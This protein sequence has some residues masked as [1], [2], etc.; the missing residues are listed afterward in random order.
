MKKLLL[1]IF[2][3]SIGLN[4]SAQCVPVSGFTGTGVA[5][6]PIQLEPV[7]ACL[8]CG[9]QER[10]ISVHTLADT[11]L[12]IELAPGNPP[13]DVTVYADFFRLIS[14]EGL[15]SGLSYT[16]DAALDTTY[17]EVENPFGYWVNQGDTTVG[18][19]ST[20][21]CIS[22]T[23]SAAD[24]TAAA[25]GGPNSDGLYPLTIFL[26]A[27]AAKFDP[28]AIANIVGYNTWVT[29]M[30]SLLETFGDTN[31]TSDGI[32]YQ[33]PVLEVIESGLGIQDASEQFATVQNQPNPFS[34][35]TLISFDLQKQVSMVQ[36]EVFDVL[37]NRIISRSVSTAK[38]RNTIDFSANGLASGIYVYTLSDGVDRVT[39]RMTVK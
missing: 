23:G 24:W 15:P 37:G 20:T 18:L 11:V 13:L 14:V 34:G 39:R 22:I 12:S 28:G 21:G 33:G 36:F 17:D 38:G 35:Q 1:S 8:D 16:T 32:R 3:I 29:D 4:A 25:N 31:F 19:S 9:D 26:D 2:T 6:L 7:Y 10:I 5:F 27:R 30:G